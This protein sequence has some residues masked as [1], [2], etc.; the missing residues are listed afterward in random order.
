MTQQET[1][2]R[3]RRG[4]PRSERARSAILDATGGLVLTRGIEAVS[5][6]AVAERASVSK[7]TIYRWWPTKER[8]VLDALYREWD[9]ARDSI[10]DT[11]SLQGDLESLLQPWVRRIRAKPYGRVIA[12]L[13]AAAQANPEFGEQWRQRFIQPRR[14]A[15]RGLFARAMKRGEISTQVRVELALDLIYGSVYHR[16]LM[17]HAPLS[18][19]F[20]GEVIEAALA[21][22]A[23]A[24]GTAPAAVPNNG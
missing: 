18:E 1:S 5:M 10:H 8:L 15:A 9:T 17:A 6:D 23:G 3:P 21:G 20:L 16:L 13:I 19:A 11:G 7:A 4:R 14:D 24:P 2:D 22:T 12:G